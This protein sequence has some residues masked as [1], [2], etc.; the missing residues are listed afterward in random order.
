M[1]LKLHKVQTKEQKGPAILM[2]V[3][4]PL[5]D[6]GRTSVHLERKQ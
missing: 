4:D 2:I 1:H 6:C 3:T 5:V